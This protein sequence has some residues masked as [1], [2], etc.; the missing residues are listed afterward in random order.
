MRLGCSALCVDCFMQVL[1]GQPNSAA[2]LMQEGRRRAD[3]LVMIFGSFSSLYCSQYQPRKL[4]YVMPFL[5]REEVRSE[6]HVK[7]T[8]RAATGIVLA[9]SSK[10]YSEAR[11]SVNI[12]IR[13]ANE[14]SQTL[15]NT[16]GALKDVQSKLE[17]SSVG[18]QAF[19]V[20]TS[21]T[22]KL[23]AESALVEMQASKNRHR[24]HRGLKIA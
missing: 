5:P 10:F 11:A 14:A 3:A 1:W 9:G 6:K 2:K 7:L 17:G 23:D 18:D 12:I 24:I 16:T 8:C 19:H 15:Y 13:T 21:T 4:C 22:H 20:L